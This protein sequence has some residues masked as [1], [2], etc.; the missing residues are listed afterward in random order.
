[1]NYN[2]NYKIKPAF[3]LGEVIITLGIIGVVAAITTPVLFA[4]IPS[5]SETLH[6]KG[7]YTLEHTVS[8]IVNSEIYYPVKKL[9]VTNP[10]DP[11]TIYYENVYGLRNTDPVIENNKTYQGPTKFCELM[12]SKFNL[13]PGTEINCTTA[14]ANPD[15]SEYSVKS[16]D[17]IEWKFPISDFSTNTPQKIV[18]KT[19]DERGPNCFYNSVTCKNP[20][21]FLYQITPEGRLFKEFASSD[22][23]KPTYGQ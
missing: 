2:I 22:K 18:F 12:A 14:A 21:K 19:S 23:I 4:V 11:A 10:D 1:M 15:S 6:K 9:T 20:D 8:D 13:Y 16:S 3:S 7:D 17:G 5:K